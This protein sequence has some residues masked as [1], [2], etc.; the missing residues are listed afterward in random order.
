MSCL[1]PQFQNESVQNYFYEN[2]LNLHENG[3]AGET[4]F[5][6]NG[7]TQTRFDTEAKGK[8]TY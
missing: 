2:N 1:L 8:M 4:H 3:R 5:H 6:M 7:F